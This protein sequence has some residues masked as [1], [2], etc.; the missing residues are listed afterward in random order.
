MVDNTP[1]PHDG[2]PLARLIWHY[3]DGAER[4]TDL[5]YG[6]HMRDWWTFIDP[7][8]EVSAGRVAW[9]GS[10]PFAQDFGSQIRLYH[11]PLD[12]PRPEAK[13]QSLQW[14][15]A[16]SPYAPLLVAMTVE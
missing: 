13:V 15:G 7:Q 1:L 11:V 3:T 2:L 14:I 8:D 5:I 10:N 4:Q 9:T 16:L 6:L 12:N